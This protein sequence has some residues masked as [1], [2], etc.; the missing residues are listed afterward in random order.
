MLAR[1]RRVRVTFDDAFRS[2]ARV[3]PALRD[4]G[5]P[6]QLFVC[7]GYARDGAPLT[8][9]ELA[10]DDP[11]ELATMTWA[12]LRSHAEEGVQIGSHGVWH[13]RLPQLSDAEV[14]SEL[15]ES[16]QAIEDEL[17]RPCP[18]FAYP[19]GEHDQRTRKLVQSCGYE[20][21][22]ALWE[23]SRRDP[24][25]QRRLDLYRRHTPAQAVVRATFTRG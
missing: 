18:D 23:S 4:L 15:T 13:G 14:R 11:A 17:R 2:A 22:F 9:P 6:V 25:A 5:V 1:F 21:A 16:K 19:Y 8:I 24:F 10:G 20:R 12:E 3:F 7:T